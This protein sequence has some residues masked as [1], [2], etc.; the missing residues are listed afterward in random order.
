[1]F[2]GIFQI[3]LY[4]PVVGNRI[5]TPPENHLLTLENNAKKHGKYISFLGAKNINQ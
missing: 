3:V 4:C 2:G 1:M 5:Q